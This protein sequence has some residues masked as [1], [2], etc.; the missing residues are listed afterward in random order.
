MPGW[1]SDYGYVITSAGHCYDDGDWV[2]Q[3]GYGWG[4][5]VEAHD[6]DDDRWP[7]DIAMIDNTTSRGWEYALADQGGGLDEDIV[8]WM[9]W[10]VIVDMEDETFNP[11]KRQGAQSGRCQG[12]V[13][14][15]DTHDEIRHFDT[16][17]ASAGGDS[18]GVHFDHD[19]SS[20]VMV[21]GLHRATHR[22]DGYARANY[23]D[24]LYDWVNLGF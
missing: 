17:A 12:I 5:V 13:K 1:H 19:T 20:E 9:D 23:I 21:S 2:G 3:G 14:Q 8:G 7:V 11:M 15:Y 6:H 16:G 10:E 18:G 4:E 22:Y 24:D